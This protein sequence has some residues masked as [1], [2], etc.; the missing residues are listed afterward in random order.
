[1]YQPECNLVYQYDASGAII[2]F[3][4][5]PSSGTATLYFFGK[6]AQGDVLSIYDANGT[7]V[8]RYNYDA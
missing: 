7:T 8:A 2:G 4:Y 5:H 3:T 6:N 1:M